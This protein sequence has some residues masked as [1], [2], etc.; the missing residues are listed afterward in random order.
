REEADRKCLE[1]S[2]ALIRRIGLSPVIE[3]SAPHV[4]EVEMACTGHVELRRVGGKAAL[5]AP[6]PE[7]PSLRVLAAGHGIRAGQPG[8]RAL[9]WH[10][11]GTG[12]ERIQ[13]CAA[14][15][16]RAAEARMVAALNASQ[17]L[18]DLARRMRAGAAPR[19]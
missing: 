8:P 4:I 1:G 14:W 2:A 19:W 13:K 12:D 9:R 11:R 16:T 15:A 18:A 17:A 5:V 6:R 3:A 10:A 7:P